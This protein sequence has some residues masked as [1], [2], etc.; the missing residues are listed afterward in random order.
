MKHMIVTFGL[1]ILAAVGVSWAATTPTTP[2]IRQILVECPDW[3]H[4]QACPSAIR[5]FIAGRLPATDQSDR[6]MGSL[7]VQLVK[8]LENQK[9]DIPEDVCMDVSTAIGIL[10]KAMKSPGQ[11]ALLENIAVNLCNDTV[12]T[13]ATNPPNGN[14]GNENGGGGNENGG[15]GNENGGNGGEPSSQVSEPSNENG[16]GG[17][18]NGGGSSEPSTPPSSERGQS[19]RGRSRYS[20]TPF[21][22]G[23]RK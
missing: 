12:Q 17:N 22:S 6:Q 20:S 9:G 21:S 11:T 2:T 1:L 19:A 16:G 4:A 18:E 15:G 8:A 13:A 7:A 14:G 5:D 23:S 3:D 10:A